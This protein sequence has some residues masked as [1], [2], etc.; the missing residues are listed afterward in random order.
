VKTS[1]VLAFLDG[2]PSGMYD[3][4]AGAAATAP[5]PKRAVNF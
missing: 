1:E 5:A 4:P 3:L 2:L